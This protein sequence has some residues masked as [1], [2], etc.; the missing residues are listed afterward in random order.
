MSKQNRGE[1]W[2]VDLRM[3]AKVRPCLVISTDVLIQ[4][5]AIVTVVTHST[6]LRNS[7]FE[8]PVKTRFLDIAC[9]FDAQSIVTVPESKFL[10]KLDTLQPDQL[11][12][13]EDAV[14]QWLKL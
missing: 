11:S 14:R 12:T 4:D 10:K 6:S 5:R 1:A 8:V 13:I 3:A 2:L 7:R 9:A